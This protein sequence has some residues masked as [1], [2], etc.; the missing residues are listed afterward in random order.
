MATALAIGGLIASVGGTLMAGQQAKQEAKYNQQVA[1]YQAEQLKAKGVEE[2]AIGQRRAGDIRRAG[3]EL[4][5]R[6]IAVAASGGAGVDNNTINTI[7]NRT[8]NQ[9]RY[10]ADI[11]MWQGASALAGR[12]DAAKL[13]VAEGKQIRRAGS[14]A[15]TGSILS[16][17]GQGFGGAA[18]IY[19]G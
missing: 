18:K 4:R 2:R 10:E 3:A 12:K 9:T 13:K 6:Q 1:N 17:V 16:A 14:N 7:I 19:Y 8:A 11:A 15:F 5:S